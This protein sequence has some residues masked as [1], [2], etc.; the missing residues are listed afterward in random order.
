MWSCPD[1]E[2]EVHQVGCLIEISSVLW[3]P[4]R[5]FIGQ[6][7][8]KKAGGGMKQKEQ[9]AVLAE[10]REGRFNVLVATCIAEEGLDIP[11]VRFL[12]LLIWCPLSCLWSPV[13]S[14]SSFLSG[15]K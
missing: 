10:F 7:T 11:H 4:R 5:R 3:R 1:A 15:I 12:F 9:K 14:L 6:G 13:Y 8:D 2:Q